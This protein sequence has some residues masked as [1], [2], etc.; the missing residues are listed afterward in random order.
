MYLIV[1]LGNPDLKYLTTFHNIGFMA[2]DRFALD[3][4]LQIN[5]KEHKALVCKTQIAGQK[6]IIAK[7]QTYMNLSGE[8]VAS[9]VNFYKI[10][11]ENVLVIYDDLDLPCG[12]IRFRKSGS[13]GSH[14]GMKN[15]VKML[16][17]TEFARARIGIAKDQNSPIPTIDYV[18]MSIPKEKQEIYKDSFGK[19][20]N[21]IYDFILGKSSE[22]IMCKYN[23]K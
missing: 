6:V 23:N 10:P 19:M 22:D 8:S 5:Q 20:S 3:N 13:A 14:N 12:T 9:L 4:N 21:L 17:N 18:L 16:S 15:I 7:P 11:L 1:G 2:I